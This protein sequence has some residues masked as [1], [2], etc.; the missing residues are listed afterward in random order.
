LAPGE[1]DVGDITLGTAVSQSTRAAQKRGT[2]NPPE[3]EK[4]AREGGLLCLN[5]WGIFLLYPYYQD[6]KSSLK[7][8][9]ISLR[10]LWW[11]WRGMWGHYFGFGARLLTDFPH[12][13]VF[14]EVER[15]KRGYAQS[16]V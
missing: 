9:Q 12:L 11:K 10:L 13:V 15:Q 1:G 7:T 3:I 16:R 5:C 14:A 8:G 4:A 6:T 2:I